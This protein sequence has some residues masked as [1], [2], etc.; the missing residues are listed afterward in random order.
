MG[1]RNRENAAAVRST[2][3]AAAFC[4]QESL[5]FHTTKGYRRHHMPPVARAYGNFAMA[6]LASSTLFCM[7]P[8]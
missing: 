2:R 6:A 7:T 1:G 3:T 8:A 5:L 4:S